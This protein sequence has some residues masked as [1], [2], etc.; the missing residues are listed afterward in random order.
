MLIAHPTTEDHYRKYAELAE[1]TWFA[2]KMNCP[3]GSYEYLLEKYLEDR[4]LNN[5]P[6]RAWDSWGVWLQCGTKRL[7]KAELVCL[8]KHLVTYRVLGAIPI[9]Y[10]YGEPN[11]LT[12]EG[13][14]ALVDVTEKALQKLYELDETYLGW[15]KATILRFKQCGVDITK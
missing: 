4:L 11:D 2:P 7:S 1:L 15:M 12:Q 14:K 13:I 8:G 10:E 5:I 3:I 6:L 9:F